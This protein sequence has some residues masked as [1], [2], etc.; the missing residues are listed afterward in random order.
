MI[1]ENTEGKNF[2][3]SINFDENNNQEFM[4]YVRF[5]VLQD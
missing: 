5:V 1:K 3:I 4:G 2:R